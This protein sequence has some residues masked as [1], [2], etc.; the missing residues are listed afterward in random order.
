MSWH[1]YTMVY[2]IIK[3][4]NNQKLR[5][6]PRLQVGF[7]DDRHPVISGSVSHMNCASILRSSLSFAFSA[8]H[9]LAWERNRSCGPR[10]SNLMK[11]YFLLIP[12][13][14]V[15]YLLIFMHVYKIEI[16]FLLID[17]AKQLNTNLT[18]CQVFLARNS[19]S[20]SDTSLIGRVSA[21]K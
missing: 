21:Q 7:F 3:Y 5:F 4:N 14:Y 6:F 2:N 10:N 17:T 16:G 9:L 1:K 12:A 15:P 11:Y 19:A 8:F 13:S 18:S 20:L